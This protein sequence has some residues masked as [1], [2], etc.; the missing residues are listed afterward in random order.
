MFLGFR[1]GQEWLPY[2]SVSVPCVCALRI[3]LIRAPHLLQIMAWGKTFDALRFPG[4][5]NLAVLSDQPESMEN[6]RLV[7][8]SA[9]LAEASFL[10]GY[11]CWLF[12]P[13]LASPSPVPWRSETDFRIASKHACAPCWLV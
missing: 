9:G 13:V 2:A 6:L 8:D 1:E 5:Q 7:S 10:Q 11:E 3:E 4:F 12:G